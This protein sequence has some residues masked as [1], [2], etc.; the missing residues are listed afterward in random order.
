M[1]EA[2]KSALTALNV[3]LIFR[4][5]GIALGIQIALGGLVTFG[6]L[7]PFTHMAWGVVLGVLAIVALVAVARMPSKP[8]RLMGI[9]I[10]IGVDILLE[11]LI[12]AAALSTSSNATL[13]N[14]IAWVHLLNSFAIFAMSIMGSGMAMAASRMAAGPAPQASAV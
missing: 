10:G 11:A 4:I 5:T 3:N 7:D 6:F 14:G 9:T 13:S 8:K 2:A 1:T 12:G